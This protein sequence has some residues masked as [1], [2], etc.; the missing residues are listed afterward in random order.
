MKINNNNIKKYDCKV[1]LELYFTQSLLCNMFNNVFH[2]FHSIGLYCTNLANFKMY[3][4]FNIINTKSLTK[5]EI[6]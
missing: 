1:I 6:F 4:Q 2:S 3:V 5:Y